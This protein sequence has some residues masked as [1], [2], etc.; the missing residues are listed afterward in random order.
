MRKLIITKL[1]ILSLLIFNCTQ[2]CAQFSK[3]ILVGE[4]EKNI[5]KKFSIFSNPWSSDLIEQFNKCDAISQAITDVIEEFFI[6]Q[7]IKFNIRVIQ[8]V[9][10]TYSQIIDETLTK[11]KKSQLVYTTNQKIKSN[12]TKIFLKSAAVL[13]VDETMQKIE[14]LELT[15]NINLISVNSINSKFLI[16]KETCGNLISSN[17]LYD[18]NITRAAF[19]M[20]S[21]FICQQN[22][23]TI[24][25]LTH[26]WFEYNSC[27]KRKVLTI[28]RFD[29]KTKKWK[30]PL[31]NHQKFKNLNGCEIIIKESTSYYYRYDRSGKLIAAYEPFWRM[32]AKYANFT[33]RMKDMHQTNAHCII[34]YIR[35]ERER[36]VAS[37][38]TSI[39]VD[40]ITTSGESFSDY[41][42]LLLPFDL[43]TWMFLICTF[44]I[45]FFIIFI[46][47]Q[48]NQNIKEF[49]YG[50]EIKTPSL[51]VISTFFGYSQTKLPK[52][53]F[54]RFIL[55][56]FVI[57]CFMV[58]TLYQGVIF[59]YMNSDMR[60]A[61]PQTIDEVF[62]R[63]YKIL[64]HNTHTTD[65]FY[66][67]IKKEWQKQIFRYAIRPEKIISDMCEILVNDEPK[68]AILTNDRHTMFVNFFC[69]KTHYKIKETAFTIP[70]G[71]GMTP[72]HYLYETVENIIQPMIEHGFLKYFYDFWAYWYFIKSKPADSNNSKP[73]SLNDLGFCFNILLIMSLFALIVFFVEI[74]KGK[75]KNNHLIKKNV[76][77]NSIIE[78][79][80]QKSI[81]NLTRIKRRFGKRKSK[82]SNQH[83]S[84]LMVKECKESVLNKTKN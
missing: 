38:F 35:K 15:K 43:I 54:A 25:L 33:L 13:F 44:G 53:N 36:A 72:N 80:N 8:P 47:N 49:V 63:G 82:N 27:D 50:K 14:K 45:A 41:E 69:K 1:L 12:K 56:N 2:V 65:L 16:Y 67:S 58:R 40:L 48:M 71:F 32:L 70:V 51:N 20:Y 21:Y 22:Y 4:T 79:K 59:D 34:Y 64:A 84:L 66:Y 75:R 30:K 39:S 62:E 81:M 61:Q 9:S 10:S 11:M 23:E 37:P 83:K 42:K 28:N 52:T 19:S 74:F 6:K 29:L 3:V 78:D 26:S 55:I 57:F 77:K 7:N 46:I 31:K 60:K 17:V 68:I 76:H 24:N 5:T 73:L 18:N